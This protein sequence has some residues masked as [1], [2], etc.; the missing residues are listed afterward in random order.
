MNEPA[1]PYASP[2]V[3]ID[4]AEGRTETENIRHAHL[5]REKSIDSISSLSLIT[6]LFGALGLIGITI[7]ALQST[8]ATEVLD[9]LT[10]FL[11][12]AVLVGV[13][14]WTGY[15]LS[16][17]TQRGRILAIVLSALWLLW[18]PVGTM[19][20][21]YFLFILL[22]GKGKMVCSPEYQKIRLSTPHIKYRTSGVAWSILLIFILAMVALFVWGSR[23]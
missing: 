22:N 19:L 11:I 5:A 23:I 16:H 8:N 1:N 4:P 3:E 17:Y 18:I 14:A 10:T 20:G 7:A 13:H 6:A 21:L 9:F 2:T 15:E 12:L